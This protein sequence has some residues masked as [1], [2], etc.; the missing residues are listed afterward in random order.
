[1]FG[2]FFSAQESLNLEHRFVLMFMRLGGTRLFFFK[3]KVKTKNEKEK[4]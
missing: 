2:S 1:M 4:T 3:L